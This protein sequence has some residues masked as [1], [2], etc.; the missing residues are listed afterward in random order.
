LIIFFD[1]ID[2]DEQENGIRN[3]SLVETV[4]IKPLLQKEITP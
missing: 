3:D 2:G 1:T 4:V